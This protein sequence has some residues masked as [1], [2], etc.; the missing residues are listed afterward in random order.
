MKRNPCNHGPK[1]TPKTYSHL[2]EKKIP[3]ATPPEMNGNLGEMNASI[4][5]R[6]RWPSGLAIALGRLG[7]IFHTFLDFLWGTT[8]TCLWIPNRHGEFPRVSIPGPGI[9]SSSPKNHHEVAFWLRAGRSSE[10]W[11]PQPWEGT[12]QKL[13]NHGTTWWLFPAGTFQLLHQGWWLWHGEFS[14][15]P[16][17][18][19]IAVLSGSFAFCWFVDPSSP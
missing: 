2:R 18:H 1:K 10:A 11:Q 8:C 12:P 9:F 17:P 6:L 7:S 4:L 16:Y 19:Y 5:V 14:N 13:E 15:S 3:G